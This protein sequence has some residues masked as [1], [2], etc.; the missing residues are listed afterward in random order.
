MNYRALVAICAV[1]FFL[2]LIYLAVSGSQPL[3]PDELRFLEEGHSLVTGLGLQADGKLGHDMPLTGLVIAGTLFISGESVFAVKLV[4]VVIS[5][6]TIAVVALLCFEISKEN[7]S[8]LLAAA[9]CSIYP[10]FI[11]YSA[12]ILSE[13]IF[14]FFMTLFFWALIQKSIGVAWQGALA[15]LMHLTRPIFLYFF[16]IIWAWQYSFQR[17][18]IQKIAF[19][20]LIM[21]LVVSPWIVRNYVV[22]GEIVIGTAS[23]GHILWEGNNPWNTTGGVSGT[24]EDTQSWLDVVPG[25]KSEL[26]ED[27]WKKSEAIAFIKKEPTHFLKNGLLKLK[28]F[29]SLWPNSR[30]H[31]HWLYRLV[32]VLSFGPVLLLSMVG[33][34]V[35][36]K[37]RKEVILIL[38]TV[39]YLSALHALILGSIRYRLPLEPLLIVLASITLV[40]L[41][42][43]YSP[44]KGQ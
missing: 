2:R 12:R 4:M 25:G 35:L 16:P 39:G 41:W 31:Q 37:H 6:L 28:R 40:N 36:K 42:G 21:T 18:P 3:F 17:V 44:G 11:F 33:A 29:W 1:G 10:F 26:A 43:R 22:F 8:A 34:V 5:T 14:L 20:I 13:T 9:I 32:S 27:Q 38:A 15:G 30:D 19:G 23:S 24:F 7:R